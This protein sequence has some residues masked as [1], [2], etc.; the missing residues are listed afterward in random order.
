MKK[1]K[2]FAFVAAV[3][4]AGTAGFTACSSDNEEVLSPNVVF[5]EMGNKGVK[6]EF[7]ISIPR[8][9]VSRM[10]NEVTQKD[11]TVAQFRGMEQIQLVPFSAEITPASQ[12]SSDVI[13]LETINKSS[14]QSVG[15][16]NYKVY[17]D[18][19]VPVG[20]SHFLFYGKAIDNEAGAKI[21]TAA[22]KFKYGVIN[23]AGLGKDFTT[24]SAVQFALEQINSNK[25]AIADDATGKAIIDLLNAIASVEGWAATENT[26]LKDLYTKFTSLT[27]AASY[28]VSIVL[29]DLY[30][31]AAH[32]D[33][34][35][36]AYKISTAI[37]EEIAKAGTPKSNQPMELKDEYKGFPAN[38]NLPDGAARIAWNG[39][40]FED[41][42]ATYGENSAN[43]TQYTYPAALWYYANTTIK[44]SD[45][46]ES[47]EY[48]D[49]ANWDNVIGTVY[50]AAGAVV[51]DNTQSVALV[52]PA[53][54]A[55][56]RLEVTIKLGEEGKDKFYDN[57]GK[58]MNV[59][60]GFT[61]KGILIGGQNA[62]KYDF[63]STA[64]GNLTIYDREVAAETKVLKNT[65][66]KANQTLALETL[67]DQPVN[68]ALELVNNG[69]EFVG[70]DGGIVP[71]GGTFYLAAQLDPAKAINR[72][73][74]GL[75]QVF[76][77]DYVTKV[78]VTI[79]NGTEGTPGDDGPGG[80]GPTIPD[81][82]SPNIELG[83]SVDLEWQE[84]LIFEPAI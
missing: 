80:G 35:D 28:Q 15:Q 74:V 34:E 67:A 26:N 41:A 69:K 8:S 73:K 33:M 79:K 22:D 14:L 77:Q 23:A 44:A 49:A 59:D 72:D 46:I 20:T 9:V 30:F 68:I 18:K 19:F 63:T 51:T 55:V 11:G 10:S 65:T 64:T 54:Y 57:A 56:G 36:P 3:L 12:K 40:K 53:Q 82:S 13:N 32:V 58:E 27:V 29:S 50:G 21:E 5:D 52:K 62:V 75:N 4:L 6:P 7:A 60:N 84:G 1:M 24:P 43:L 42:T 39:T 83:T 17:A 25:S 16:M 78:T 37:R 61:L 48:N 70:R 2:N 45:N 31:S 81:L 71:A 38:L 76:K 47:P 66:S